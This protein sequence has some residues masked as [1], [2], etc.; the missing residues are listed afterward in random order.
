[1]RDNKNENFGV[2][3]NAVL[4]FPVLWAQVVDYTSAAPLHWA[5][6]AEADKEQQRQ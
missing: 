6:G 4:W 5:S 3:L 2:C 1:M